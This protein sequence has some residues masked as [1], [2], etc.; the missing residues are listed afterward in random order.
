M[1]VV[2][3][4]DVLDDERQHVRVIAAELLHSVARQR[5]VKVAELITGQSRVMEYV[6]RRLGSKPQLLPEL[7]DMLE[8]QVLLLEIPRAIVLC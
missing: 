4:V 7:A 2:L 5:G 6:G 8:I 1:S 3:L